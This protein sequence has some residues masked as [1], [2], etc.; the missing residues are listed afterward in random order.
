LP[1]KICPSFPW[2][3]ILAS[4]RPKSAT[5]FGVFTVVRASEA[6]TSNEPVEPVTPPIAITVD[7]ASA[8]NIL[9]VFFFIVPLL[10]NLYP[11]SKII[12]NTIA[13]NIIHNVVFDPVFGSFI[14]MLL[15]MV[16]SATRSAFVPV[17]VNMP[18]ESLVNASPFT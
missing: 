4:P 12:P 15:I 8:I 1:A 7:K 10:S 11:N 18:S 9:K 13:T 17:T 6:C 2:I 16:I 14:P 3:V 5:P